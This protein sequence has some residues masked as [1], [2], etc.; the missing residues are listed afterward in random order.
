[1]SQINTLVAEMAVSASDQ[2]AGLNE[3]NSTVEQM[4]QVTQ[5]NASMVEES[6]AA[7]FS[8]ASESQQLTELINKFNVGAEE[9]NVLRVRRPLRR[10]AQ[11]LRPVLEKAD[12]GRSNV[13]S[14][15]KWQ[16]P[17][18]DEWEEF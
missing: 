7:S 13:A 3:I 14:V 10:Y 11:N 9:R 16:R 12:G 2:A 8:L 17:E 6:S 5:Q 18:P 15:R 4:D 1:M